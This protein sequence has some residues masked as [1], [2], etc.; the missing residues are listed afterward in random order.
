MSQTD[1]WVSGMGGYHT[2][3]IPALVKTERGTLLAFCEGRKSGRGDSGDIDLLL[4]R[5]TDGGQ[6]WTAQQVLWDGGADACGNPCPV[7]NR[8]TG[9][10]F[11]LATRNLGADTEKMIIAQTGKGTRT[12]WVL[13][14]ADEGRT[15]SKPR[16]IT[17][18]VKKN[19]WTWYATGPGAGIQLEYGPHKGRLIVPCD[20]IEAITK[21]YYSHA[22]YSD[23][24]GRSWRLGGSTPNHRVNECEAVELARPA[25]RL[26][27]NMRNYDPAERARQ[28]AVSDDGGAAWKD[29]KHD[30]ALVEP[31]CQASIRRI[32]W[33]QNDAPGVILF[34]NPAS[35]DRRERMTVR[36]SYDDAATWPVAKTIYPGMSAYSCL[37]KLDDETVGLLYERDDGGKAYGRIAFARFALDWLT[38]EE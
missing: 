7:V 18:A 15:W 17:T 2:Y 37:A 4:R 19:D 35:R 11:L 13:Q 12:V 24:G 5:S 22:I 14:S 20:H 36:L 10:I 1:L 30:P 23:D 31:I 8:K 9:E 25:G 3:R 6:T 29:Q 34:A 21:H 38:K 27:L 33:P 32:H 28:T 16:E 26:M